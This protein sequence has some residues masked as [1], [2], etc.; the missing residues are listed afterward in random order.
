MPTNY[1]MFTDAINDHKAIYGTYTPIDGEKSLRKLLPYV[2]GQSE[3]PDDGEEYDMVLCYEFTDGDPDDHPDPSYWRCF[4]VEPFENMAIQ[5]FTETWV[6]H[7]MTGKQR[8]RQNCVEIID[9]YRR[10]NP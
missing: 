1:E 8:K 5:N 2:L 10:P 3:S 6:P 7:K 4:E 9:V